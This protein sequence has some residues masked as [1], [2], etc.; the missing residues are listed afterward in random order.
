MKNFILTISTG[1]IFTSALA[2]KPAPEKTFSFKIDGAI[3][4]YAGKFIYLH[5]RWDEKD[6]T[7][8]AKVV[9][10]KFA[11]SLKSIDPNMYWFTTVRENNAQPNTIF[12][13]DE[14]T[15]KANL[16]GDSMAYSVISGGQAQRDY[17]EYR[18]MI[19]NFVL[20]QQ[21][22][23]ADYNTAIQNNDVNTQN[24]IKA[25]YQN[26]NGQFLGGLKNYVKTH[27]KS[28]VSGF[29]IYNDL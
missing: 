1:L 15:I 25:E 3:S 21:K 26:L 23:Q 6:F 7:D 17:L 8:S 22:M 24:S 14:G 9:K 18:Q 29:I 16:K 11:F 4:N 5:H 13:V 12:F 2:Q 27:T 28:P 10:G 20:V 19:N